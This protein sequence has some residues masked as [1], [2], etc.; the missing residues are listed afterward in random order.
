MPVRP[1]GTVIASYASGTVANFD[2]R[3]GARLAERRLHGPVVHLAVRGA[4]LHAASELGD[5]IAVDLGIFV[6]PHCDVLR[7]VWEASPEI[8]EDGGLVTRAPPE[9]PRCRP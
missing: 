3:T 8:W 7:K 1:G 4:T 6:A 5:A 9:D 2:R